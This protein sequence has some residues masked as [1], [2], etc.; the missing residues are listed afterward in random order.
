MRELESIH[1][2]KI[3]FVDGFKELRCNSG[4]KLDSLLKKKLKII[5]YID[6]IPCSP[7]AIKKIKIWQS[8]I[9][10][11]DSDVPYIIVLNSDSR[12][13]V[14]MMDSISLSYPLMYYDS[15]IFGIKNKLEGL[16]ARNRTFLLDKDDKVIVIGE[17]FGMKAMSKLYKKYIDS[18][19]YNNLDY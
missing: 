2:N 3:E 10:A 5:S 9:R 6:D 13:F 18:L 4:V 14:D 1:G 12:S 8:E 11:I 15:K 19:L 17:P 16:L 7:C